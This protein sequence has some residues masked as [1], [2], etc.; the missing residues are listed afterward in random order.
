MRRIF[1]GR[2]MTSISSFRTAGEMT[3]LKNL[4]RKPASN[5][6]PALAVAGWACSLLA[7]GGAEQVDPCP[8]CPGEPTKI[9]VGVAEHVCQARRQEKPVERI[10]ERHHLRRCHGPSGLVEARHPEAR[11][12]QPRFLP[13]GKDSAKKWARLRSV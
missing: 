1:S 4:A 13:Q 3:G 10:L 2:V 8:T 11:R 5:T 6:R 12:A 9:A 7:R